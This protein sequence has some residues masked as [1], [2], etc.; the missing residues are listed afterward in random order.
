MQRR[1]GTCLV[2]QL[3]TP[4]RAGV[5]LQKRGE[6]RSRRL[7]LEMGAQCL[8]GSGVESLPRHLECHRRTFSPRKSA[9]EMGLP[10]SRLL[11][12]GPRSPRRWRGD[13]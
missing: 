9:G 7:R 4:P 1:G 8:E 10:S 5:L 13:K 12:P 2:P 11:L 6:S 3:E